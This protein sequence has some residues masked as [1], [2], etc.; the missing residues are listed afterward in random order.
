MAQPSFSDLKNNLELKR[1]SNAVKRNPA[2]INGQDFSSTRGSFRG[3]Y[4]DVTFHYP[5]L[6]GLIKQ[7]D[8]FR[9]CLNSPNFEMYVSMQLS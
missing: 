2:K 4:Y 6:M 3:V 7:A 1:V 9:I 5:G 8:F